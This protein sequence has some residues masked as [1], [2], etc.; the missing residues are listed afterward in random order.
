MTYKSAS[1]ITA[2]LLSGCVTM[3]EPLPPEEATDNTEAV[4]IKEQ[5]QII[6]NQQ[7]KIEELEQLLAKQTAAIKQSNI[8]EREQEQVI[9][10]ASN[11]I[12]RAQIKL[13]RLATKSSSASIIA[14]A[15]I[16]MDA[17]K[18]QPT[19]ETEAQLHA[20]A[21]QLLDAAALYFSRGDYATATH[22]ASQSVEFTNMVA[23]AN[24]DKP[25]RI[26]VAFNTPVRLVASNN[27][28]L[29]Q[30][31]GTHSAVLTVL[32]K[33]V[34]MTATAYQGNWLRVQTDQNLQGW[35][36]NTLVK[37]SIVK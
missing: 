7:N 8:R 5:K 24:R 22:Y 32:E 23:D 27:V 10:A 1:A 13:H 20:D 26:T 11:E 18:Q 25:N 29:R 34:Y 35:V 15:E 2:L 9:E 21:K 19:M 28:N 4:L 17:L 36:S 33:G 3:M 14:E 16:A 37:V 31:P 6:E 12:T 30:M